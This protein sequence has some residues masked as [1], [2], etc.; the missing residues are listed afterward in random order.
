MNLTFLQERLQE[1]VDYVMEQSLECD[2]DSGDII[3]KAIDLKL[4]ELRPID[5][6]QSID[7]E[8]E[9]YFTIWSPK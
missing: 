4:V 6:E 5:E 2:V 8:K 3:D 7:G 9:H 1:F